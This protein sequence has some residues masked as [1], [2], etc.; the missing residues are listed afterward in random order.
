MNHLIDCMVVFDG[1]EEGHSDVL[2]LPKLVAFPQ[3]FVKVEPR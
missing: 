2:L 1:F 3:T